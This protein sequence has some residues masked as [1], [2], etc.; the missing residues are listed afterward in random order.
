MATNLLVR[1]GNKCYPVPIVKALD[2]CTD[3]YSFASPNQ[4]SDPKSAWARQRAVRNMTK[5]QLLKYALNA[6]AV[7]E[8][9]WDQP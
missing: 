2:T 9:I 3:L 1:R 7:L 8:Y 6:H 4:H 5:T